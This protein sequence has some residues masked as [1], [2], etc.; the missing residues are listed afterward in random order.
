MNPSRTLACLLPLLA[1]AGTARA[2][3][4]PGPPF[5][6]DDPEPVD[7]HHWEVYIASM[8]S[9]DPGVVSGTFPHIEVNYGALPNLQ[10][11]IIAPAA[12][13]QVVGG[14]RTYGYGD[15]ELGA[16]FRFVQEGKYTPMVGVFPLVEMPTGAPS[17]GLGAGQTRVF[18][19]VW[20][21][22][23]FG[24]WMS[25]G[26][27]GYWHNP[28]VGNRD[29]W[30]A[31]WEFQNQVT[32]QLALGAELFFTTPQFDGDSNRVGFNVGAMYDF[33][34]GHHLLMSIGKSVQGTNG[35]SAYLA[36]Q[37]TFG[38]HEKADAK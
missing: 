30:F 10:L 1:L 11:H 6:T 32:K 37:W 17:K 4:D 36:Y 26:G 3:P 23:S 25:Y 16:K 12:F 9:H 14:P 28:G 19:P 18:L 34:D 21:Q 13:S 2:M 31:G 27:G 33:D 15:T 38:P 29:Y 35:L 20:L 5:L 8:Y 7:F 24:N 22:K